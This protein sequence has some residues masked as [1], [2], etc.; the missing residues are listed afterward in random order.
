MPIKLDLNELSEQITD[1]EA[2]LKMIDE[3]KDVEV[4]DKLMNIYNV[5]LALWAY[6]NTTQDKDAE[7]HIHYYQNKFFSLYFEEMEKQ[8][9]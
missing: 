7:L 1:Q 6:W 4:R 2:M 8:N 9:G 5:I 3:I